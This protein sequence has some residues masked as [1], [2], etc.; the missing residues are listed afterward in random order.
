MMSRVGKACAMFV[1][2]IDTGAR[3]APPLNEALFASQFVV[4]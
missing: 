3:Q 4:V 1:R 2:W